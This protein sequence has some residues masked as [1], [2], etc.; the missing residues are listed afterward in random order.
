MLTEEQKAA[1]IKRHAT[2]YRNR[3]VFTKAL[4]FTE[5]D[6]AALISDV[7]QAVRQE[8]RTLV[9]QC[10]DALAEE[11]A[12]WDIDPPLHHVLTSHDACVSWLKEHAHAD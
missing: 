7:E 8:M 4:G 12:A 11:L 2:T 9:E 10:R 1:L 6:L 5:A 3:V